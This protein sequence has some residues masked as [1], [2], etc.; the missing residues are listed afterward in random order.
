[1]F[2]LQSTNT[3]PNWLESWKNNAADSEPLDVLGPVE[4]AKNLELNRGPWALNR[5]GRPWVTLKWAQ[6]LDGA[7]APSLDRQG[8]IAWLTGKAARARVHQIRGQHQA[9]LSGVASVLADDPRLTVRQPPPP[10]VTGNNGP[11][12]ERG[13]RKGPQR[14]VLDPR[15]RTPQHAQ[16]LQSTD[17]S[18]HLSSP[19]TDGAVFERPPAGPTVIVA[20]R[21][22]RTS[23][24]G[25]RAR[26][27]NLAATGA[28]VWPILPTPQSGTADARGAKSDGLN[29]LMT[30][31]QTAGIASVMVE[32][33]PTTHQNFVRAGL[34]DE[35]FVF[36]APTLLG[37]GKSVC[38]QNGLTLSAAAQITDWET[39]R[40]GA[41][42]LIHGVICPRPRPPKAM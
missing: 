23:T 14:I 21:T 6:T 38:G 33:G 24:P 20:N 31:L 10:P 39:H 35:V 4:F 27:E 3:L 11:S 25:M 42:L 7:V 19:L 34:V 37:G 40:L 12:L 18:T 15:L 41:D 30:K 36:V 26:A 5:L 29:S 17:P 2:G 1:M 32:G 13:P 16:I 8:E 28:L 22:S 9:I